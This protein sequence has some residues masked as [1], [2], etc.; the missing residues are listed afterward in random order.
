MQLVSQSGSGTLRNGP[1]WLQGVVMQN[2]GYCSLHVK[3]TDG[4]V[5]H[6]HLDHIRPRLESTDMYPGRQSHM[7]G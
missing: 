4:H 1:T 2:Q 3:L 6:C 7:R 5:V